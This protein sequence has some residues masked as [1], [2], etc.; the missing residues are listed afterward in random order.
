MARRARMSTRRLCEAAQ[1]TNAPRTAKALATARERLQRALW[2]RFWAHQ[3]RRLVA[4]TPTDTVPVQ[5]L[6]V[7]G[8]T[9]IVY[10]MHRGMAGRF[11][12]RPKHRRALGIA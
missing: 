8:H 11:R 9:R 6:P 12:P 1:L 7:N 4:A 5:S 10:P 3:P 2:S